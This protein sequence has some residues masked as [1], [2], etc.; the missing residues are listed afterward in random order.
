MKFDL[1]TQRY[2]DWKVY[3][4]TPIKNKYG[5]HVK[6]IYADGTSTIQ[7]SGYKTYQQH[8]VRW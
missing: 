1:Y 4:V 7:Q 8:Y 6:L 3:N 2:V 5:F